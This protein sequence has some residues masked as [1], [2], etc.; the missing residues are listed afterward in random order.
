MLSFEDALRLVQ[1]RGELM[2]TYGEGEMSAFPL[3]L[4]TIKEAGKHF[5]NVYIRNK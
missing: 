3:D 1:K 4:D 5:I 2:G